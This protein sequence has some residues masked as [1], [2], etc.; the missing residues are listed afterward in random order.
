MEISS[1]H[2]NF[3]TVRARDLKFWHNVHHPLCVQC[4]MC[5]VS[6]VTCHVSRVTYLVSHVWGHMSQKKIYFLYS[7]GA[8]WWRVCYQ[9][10]LPRLVSQCWLPQ[11]LETYLI[12]KLARRL[13]YNISHQPKNS[14]WNFQHSFCPVDV[15]RHRRENQKAICININTKYTN[16]PTLGKH[17]YSPW[18]DLWEGRQVISNSRVLP[19]QHNLEEILSCRLTRKM[20]IIAALS[21]IIFKYQVSVL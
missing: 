3:Q 20:R 15:L 18:T 14:L 11:T 8:S 6:R 12:N 1:N 5:H 7:V 10:G 2:H 13:L 19:Y 17:S 9:R 21:G 16:C 4:V